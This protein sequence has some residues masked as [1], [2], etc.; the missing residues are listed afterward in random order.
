MYDMDNREVVVEVRD[1]GAGI[2]RE[3]LQRLTDPFFTTKRDNGGTGLGLSVSARI[4]EEHKGSMVFS[5]TP[6]QG[7]TVTLRL[8]ATV[9]EVLT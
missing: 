7:T 1:E 4:V 5:S 2:V 9:E 6:G 8:P 3:N